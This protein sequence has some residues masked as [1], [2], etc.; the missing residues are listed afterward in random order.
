MKGEQENILPRHEYPRP[1]FVRKNNWINLNG[2][3]NFTFDDN[4]QGLKEEW[5]K[6]SNSKIINKK[7]NVG[8]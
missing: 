2:E 5:Y 3:W 7:L 1:Q 8:T 6:E 4:N